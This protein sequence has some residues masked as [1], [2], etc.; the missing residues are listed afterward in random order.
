M[1]YKVHS[2]IWDTDW[3]KVNLPKEVI[4]NLPEDFNEDEYGNLD[5]YLIN[6]ASDQTGWCISWCKIDP[7]K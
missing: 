3:E 5:E 1:F 2:I 4:I 6:E 7:I